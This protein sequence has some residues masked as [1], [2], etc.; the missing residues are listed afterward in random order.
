M[1]KI[2]L[3]YSRM[4]DYLECPRRYKFRYVDKE[5][6]TEDLY[7]ACTGTIKQKIV[8]ILYNEDWL[9]RE[10]PDVLKDKFRKMIPDLFKDWVA[11]VVKGGNT[12]DLSRSGRSSQ[13]LI[14]EITTGVDQIFG[15]IKKDKL[16]VSPAN[17]NRSEVDGV[18]EGKNYTLKGRIDLV[19][20]DREKAPII[21]DGKDTMI[22]KGIGY[23]DPDQLYAY[24]LM[25]FHQFGSYP[26]KLGFMMFR[27]N[28]VRWIDASAGLK[29]FDEKADKVAERIKQGDYKAN[30]GDACRWCRYKPKC[31]DHS[32]WVTSQGIKEE[33]F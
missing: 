24:A 31:K 21:V 12:V 32:E 2:Y 33:T 22:E 28:T 4:K 15:I 3:T 26:S 1:I 30:V 20:G 29:E 16:L 9:F 13:A 5:K 8:E 6:V 27:F 10:K 7:N 17:L 25:N 18:Y 14:D 23:N 19:I 11:E